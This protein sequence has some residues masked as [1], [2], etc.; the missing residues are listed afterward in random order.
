MVSRDSCRFS[1]GCFARI[2]PAT[3]F[4]T[5]GSHSGGGEHFAFGDAKRGAFGFVGAGKEL[6]FQ[7][8]EAVGGGEEAIAIVVTHDDAHGLRADFDDEIV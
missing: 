4:N 1:K 3:P 7:G 6:T 2:G 5:S 8:I